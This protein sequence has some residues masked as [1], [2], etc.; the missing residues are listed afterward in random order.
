MK[1]IYKGL[2]I[3]ALG[4]TIG[5]ARAIPLRELIFQTM[6]QEQSGVLTPQEIKIARKSGAKWYR[7]HPDC[8]DTNPMA[9]TSALAKFPNDALKQHEWAL[10]WVIGNMMAAEAQ[11]WTP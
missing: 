6:E 3:L 4:L 10:E 8:P 2:V 5:N 7:A 1:R 9:K 11:L